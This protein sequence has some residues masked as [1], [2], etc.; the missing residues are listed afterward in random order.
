MA[1]MNAIKIG[2][3]LGTILEVEN[4]DIAGIVCRQHLRV[5]VEINILRPLVPGFYIPREGKESLWVSFKYERL[6]DYCTICGLIGHKKFTCPSA[7]VSSLRYDIS[8]KASPSSSPRR[9][10]APPLD[11][12]DSGI[13]SEGMSSSAMDATL[14]STSSQLQLVSSSISTR[15]GT[16]VQQD[17]V[18]DS[19]PNVLVSPTQHMAPRI[20]SPQLD[21]Q[22]SVEV[23]PSPQCV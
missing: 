15:F 19:H 3:A 13:S 11:D 20:C 12:S 21:G 23:Q 14:S 6:A 22:P 8:L 2:K 4:Y 17:H 18:V 9:F 5:E 7:T 1:T 16:H 10:S